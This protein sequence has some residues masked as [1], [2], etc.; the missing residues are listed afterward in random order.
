M[1]FLMQQRLKVLADPKRFQI[2]KLTCQTFAS[3]C[4]RISQEETGCCVA[5]VVAATG[6]AQ[7]TVTHHLK[8]LEEVGLVL[9]EKRGTWACYFANPR[10]VAE[11]IA[12]LQS[13]LIPPDCI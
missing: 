6:L 10:A 3:C 11:L 12:W 4:E 8:A 13:E 1:D 2:L 9:R 5:D 7:P